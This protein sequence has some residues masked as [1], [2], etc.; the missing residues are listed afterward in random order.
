MKRNTKIEIT[1]MLEEHIAIRVTKFLEKKMQNKFLYKGYDIKY[2]S[3]SY[4]DNKKDIHNHIPFGHL[5]KV[6]IKAL[7]IKQTNHA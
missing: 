4:P 5:C 3:T 7:K 2:L 1:L 6:K